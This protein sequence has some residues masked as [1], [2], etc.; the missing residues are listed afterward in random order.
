MK[1]WIYFYIV[2]TIQK[3]SIFRKEP[4]WALGIKIDFTS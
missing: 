4:G 2:H 3:G 1:T